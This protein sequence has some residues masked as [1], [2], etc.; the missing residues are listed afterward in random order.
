MLSYPD[1][2]KTV[3]PTMTISFIPSGHWGPHRKS[4][5]AEQHSQLH[6]RRTGGR[7][8]LRPF[9]PPHQRDKPAVADAAARSVSEDPIMAGP[10]SSAETLRRYCFIAA[11]AVI[12]SD[13][14]EHSVMVVSLGYGRKG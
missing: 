8:V 1:K 5:G 11:G 14:P 13:V 4:Q 3:P 6:R 2:L 12:R 10:P 9:L 7:R